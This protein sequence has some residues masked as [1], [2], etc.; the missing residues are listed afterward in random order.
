MPD[1][2]IAELARKKG[3]DIAIDLTGYTENARDQILAY[4]A[5]PIQVSYLGY[6]GSMGADFIDY[7]IADCTLIPV[8][9]QKFYSEK[10]VHLPN[11]YQV[12]SH[13]NSPPNMEGGRSELG[14]P[15]EGFVFCCFNDHYKITPREFDIWMRLL[16][17]VQGSVLWLRRS[18]KSSEA[19]L[20]KEAQDRAIDPSRLIFAEKCEYSEYLIRMTKADLFLDTFN[21]NAGAMA[22]DALW[23]GLPILTKQGDSYTARMASSLLNAIDLPELITSTENDYEQIAL[24][25]ATHPNKLESLKT[26]LSIN[27]DNTSLFDTARFTKN[28][29][30][31]YTQMYEK[32]LANKNPEHLFIKE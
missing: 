32:Y 30:T 5:A 17:K 2:E 11:C 31:A 18:N 13:S 6:P 21:Y 29:E 22:N 1:Q 26:K 10:I 27:R 23:S 28:I 19:N 12:S 20:K 9:N 4:R 16:G 25:L 8:E 15:E 24:D 14:L 3:I 7:L